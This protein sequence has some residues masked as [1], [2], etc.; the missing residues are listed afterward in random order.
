MKS[1]Y[2]IINIIKN[3][4]YRFF[5]SLRDYIY[6]MMAPLFHRAALKALKGKKILRCVF[7]VLSEADWKYDYVF[8]KMLVSQLFEPIILICPRVG[9]GEEYSLL[10]Q[11]NAWTFFHDQLGY[12]TMMAKNKQSYVDVR[13]E[14]SPDIIFYCAPYRTIHHNYFITKYPDILSVYVP[15]TFNNSSDYSNFHDGLVHNLVWRYYAETLEHK[16]YSLIHARNKGRNVVV[17]GYPGIDVFLDKSY[18]PSSSEWKREGG[19][20]K[21]IIWAPHHTIANTGSVIFSC[22][23]KYCDFMVE[24]AERYVDKVQ[25]VLKPHPLLR[26]KLESLW[27]KEKTDNYFR[28]WIEMPNTSYTEGN[29][30]DLFMTS[31][32]MIHDCGSFIA[33][34]L[35]L[36]K[37]VMRT[38][39]DYPVEQMYNGFTV[40][41]IDVHYQAHSQKDIEEFILNV[42]NGIDPLKDKRSR[43]VSSELIPTVPPSDSIISDILYSIDKQV[44][45]TS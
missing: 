20:M 24:L 15:Y 11:K 9:L 7:F 16:Q 17:T 18:S 22:F 40:R 29:Y 2:P 10:K 26:P 45:Y 37:P 44:L 32:A 43:F 14:L 25:F 12:P 19:N 21:K 31:D 4:V 3:K 27:G 30:V 23:L 42:I 5:C 34:Y 41:C 33:E 36:N 35:Y 39:N 38:M 1:V 6:I 28:K 8:R 13:K